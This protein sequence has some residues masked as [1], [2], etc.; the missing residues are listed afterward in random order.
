MAFLPCMFGKLVGHAPS[1]DKQDSGRGVS[2]TWFLANIQFIRNIFSWE[3]FSTEVHGYWQNELY[4]INVLLKI[5]K[6]YATK[7]LP[8]HT[9]FL[10][11]FL[12]YTLKNKKS[13][14]CGVFFSSCLGLLSGTASKP[15]F[16][17]YA[18]LVCLTEHDCFFLNEWVILP[19]K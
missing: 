6:C 14:D 5:Q 7:N 16:F 2:S 17:S 8:L 3:L 19:Y 9:T 15:F 1:R 11:D 4:C 12:M 10:I 18:C 13:L